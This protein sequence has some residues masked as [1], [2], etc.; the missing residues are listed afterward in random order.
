VPGSL[1]I[2]TV[3]RKPKRGPIKS[4]HIWKL[5]LNVRIPWLMSQKVQVEG[6]KRTGNGEGNILHVEKCIGEALGTVISPLGLPYCESAYAE[7]R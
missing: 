6:E 2:S 5:K 1:P 3:R 4:E 7:A